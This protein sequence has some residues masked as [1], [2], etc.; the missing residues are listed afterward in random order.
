MKGIIPL[1]LALVIILS[2]C[3]ENGDWSYDEPFGHVYRVAEVMYQ[4]DSDQEI[5]TRKIFNI[6]EF[7]NLWIMD[8]IS[9][10]VFKLAGEFPK[11]RPQKKDVTSASWILQTEDSAI[12]YDLSVTKDRSVILSQFEDDRL[13]WKYR[14]DR[15]DMLS[16][17]V[18]SKGER[19]SLEVDWYYSNTYPDDISQLSSATIH[20]NGSVGFSIYDC[21]IDSVA[22]YEEY[23]TDAGVEH[24]E[25]LLQVESGLG[26]SLATKHKTT[27][28][29]ALY[30]IPYKN[31]EYIFY[32]KYN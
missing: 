8:D 11:Y 19:S 24:S 25:Y 13:Q 9:T 5:D 29:Y 1:F 28:Q 22:V 31:G 21:S 14:L 15:I 30:R 6:D 20:D 10:Y 2:G 3:R 32:L 16:V 18:V 17:N 12:M 7:R 23:Y 27:G 4:T 26:L